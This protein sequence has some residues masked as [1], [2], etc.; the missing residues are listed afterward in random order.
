MFGE[1]ILAD[2]PDL[3][4][5]DFPIS[6]G[7]LDLYAAPPRW[8]EACRERAYDH[9]LEMSI[10]RILTDNDNGTTLIDF[11]SP[12]RIQVQD[13][14]SLRIDRRHRLAHRTTRCQDLPT[15]RPSE[16]Y[17]DTFLPTTIGRCRVF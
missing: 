6:P 13:V 2:G 14:I 9:R 7:T 4:N 15:S 1:S 16:P 17:R 3:I 8:V 12:R 10:H 5:R 11:T